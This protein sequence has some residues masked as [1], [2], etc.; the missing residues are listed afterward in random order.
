MNLKVAASNAPLVAVPKCILVV[1]DEPLIRLVIC[2]DLREA[3]FEVVEACNADE[4]IVLLAALTPDL[5]SSDV[6]MPG[7]I[8][9]SGLLAFVKKT[10]PHIPV[11]IA[12]GNWDPTAKEMES[13]ARILTKPFTAD[14]LLKAIQEELGID[15]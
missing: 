9:G 15:G 13:A 11:I 10:Y 5:I 1:E 3:G 8:D 12:S 14:A 7:S 2:D 6:Q 4:A